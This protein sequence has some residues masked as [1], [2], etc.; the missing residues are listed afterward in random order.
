MWKREK[1]P[2]KQNLGVLVALPPPTLWTWV[3]IY[4][5]WSPWAVI[6]LQMGEKKHCESSSTV[7]KSSSM[8]TTSV[9]RVDICTVSF[10]KFAHFWLKLR[11]LSASWRSPLQWWLCH[12]TVCPTKQRSPFRK[13]MVNS[14]VF[15]GKVLEGGSAT[16][17]WPLRR[18]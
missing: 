4:R 17:I 7:S 6:S 15:I 12:G 8:A 10:Q 3:P 16:C 1:N 9:V 11:L 14:T 2:H 18:V 5:C 13:P